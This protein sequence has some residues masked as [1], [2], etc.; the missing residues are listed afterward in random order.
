MNKFLKSFIG[1]FIIV[2]IIILTV[3]QIIY[4]NK[5]VYSIPTKIQYKIGDDFEYDGMLIKVSDYKIYRGEELNSKYNNEL[6]GMVDEKDILFNLTITNISDTNKS[7]NASGSGIMYG[8]E[9][10]GN[11]N[12]FLFQYFNPNKKGII[13]LAEGECETVTLAFPIDDNDE[14]IEYI[15]SLYPENIRV[16]IR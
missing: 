5:T 1:I 8:H 13:T 4:I 14:N 9:S 3:I 2:I 16:K 11:V 15:I 10:G 6:T 12:P 7:Y